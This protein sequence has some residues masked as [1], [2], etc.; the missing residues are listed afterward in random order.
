MSTMAEVLEQVR[1][2][3]AA[4]GKSRYRIWQE[5]G[6]SQAQLSMLMDGTRGLSIEALERLA[7]CL[8]L[9]IVIRRKG[10]RKG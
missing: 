2:A 7:D 3:I 6:I 1:K 9:D 5:T 8:G 10:R 4:S